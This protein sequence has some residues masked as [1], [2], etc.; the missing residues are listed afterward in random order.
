MR[1]GSL[2]VFAAVVLAA[3]ISGHA[4]SFT[5]QISGRVIDES[6]GVVPGAEVTATHLATGVARTVV[7]NDQGIYRL[8]NLQPGRYRIEAELVG[9]KKFV[10]EPITLQVNDHLAL[11]IRLQVGEV[12]EVITV[13]GEPPLLETETASFGSVVN[14]R[15]IQEL[16]LN[17]R[18]S[19]AL[20]VL[21]PGVI[22][23]E[24]FGTGGGTD[25]GRNWFKSDFNV[26]GGQMRGQEILL[27][28][29]PSTSSDR[30]FATYIP[31]V[32]STQE[33]KVQANSFSAEFG[34]TTG[35]VLNIVTKSGTNEFHGTAYEFHRNSV[36]DANNF[37]ANRAGFDKTAFRRH[38]FGINTGGPI[39]KDRTFFFTAYEGFRQAFPDTRISTVPTALQRKGDFS[40]TFARD[41]KLITIYDPLTLRRDAQGNLVRDSFPGNIIPAN[42]FDPV[43]VAALS[44]YPEPNLP[45]DPVTGANNYI[46]GD[47]SITDRDRWDFRV[48]QNF[49]QTN[50][51]FG[52]L[53]Y[54][55]SDRLTPRNWDLPSAHNARIQKDKFYHAVLGDTHTFSPS[56][57][58]ELRLSFTRGH[59]QQTS[60]SEG[61]DLRQLKFPDNYVQ[62]A[63]PHFPFFNVSDMT[64]LG[65]GVINN[66][67]RNTFGVQ[68]NVTK[69]LDRH[70]F[71][72]GL[73]IRVLDFHAFQ[74]TNPTGS[75][76]FGRLFTQGPDPLRARADAGFGLASF[77][78]GMGTGGSINHTQGLSLRR[79][80][81]SFY[82]Q[83][84]WKVTPRFTLNL[85]LRYDLDVGQRERFNRLTNLDLTSPSPLGPQVGLDLK[86]VL[87]YLGTNGWPTNQLETD[88]NNF[89]PR[90]GLAY[91]LTDR[92]VVRAGYG[93]FYVPM[94]VIADGA[95]GFNSSTPWIATI[96]NLRPEHLLNNPF[97]QGFNL[98]REER[99]PLT[100]V[101]FGISGYIRDEPVGYTQQW[102]L[103]L[104]HQVAGDFVLDLAYWGNKGTKLQ[105]SGWRENDLP[106]E[107]LALK[108][109]LNERVPNPFFGVIPT[110][111]LSGSTVTRRQLLL[112]FPQYTGVTRTRV[113]AGSQI[114]HA[115]TLKVEKRMSEG[116]SVVASYTNSKTISDTPGRDTSGGAGGILNMEN[117]RAER[118]LT[119]FDVPQRLVVS[120]IYELPFGRGKRLGGDWEGLA[121]AL[122]GGWT[123]SGFTTFQSGFPLSINRPAVKT[124]SAKLD[125]PTIDRWF[126][127]SVFSPADPFT[128]G[129]VGQVEP[130]LRADGVNNF[131]FTLAKNFYIQERFRLQFRAEFFNAFNTPQFAQPVDSVTNPSFGRVTS[132][133]NAPRE[134]QFALK[135]FW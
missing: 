71:K 134:I 11:E 85:G 14:E 18:D 32:D 128:F 4:Q 51:L 96:D 73:D 56:L 6:G 91:K 101:G 65:N 114:Y 16:P 102:N 24:G 66:Q 47:Q 27:D 99:D 8:L 10:Q 88:K 38:Q 79:V 80:Y 119:P 122:L 31:P 41:G 84:D 76:N 116:L 33:F 17:V 124:G 44:F 48:D 105:Y 22:T 30:S 89:G 53:S 81:Y 121:N 59:P 46:F 28:G 36:L 25:V 9:F 12:S 118:S 107:F 90:L 37:F 77:L 93:I 23:A 68:G 26:G 64:A 135:L 78:L 82:V 112:P 42:R 49:G 97:P 86:G 70:S 2:G 7:S 110:G 132:Q 125:R 1:R 103:S 20:I 98:P 35:G 92:T 123:F 69:L 54:E 108:A 106:N 43:A 111:A 52:R 63:A 15:T 13:T 60:V 104:Q 72:T 115:F 57:I 34:R 117:R 62:V 5:A 113:S 40:Q 61:F 109:K 131:D 67:P 29:A 129:N 126:D 120:F 50:K 19:L 94:V 3:W 100:N 39:F 45:G 58:G 75:F 55:T 133:A 21:T 130:D 87:R 95:I 83:D 74:D 127:T